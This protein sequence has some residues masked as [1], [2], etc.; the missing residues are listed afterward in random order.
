[1]NAESKDEFNHGT[2]IKMGPNWDRHSGEWVFHYDYPVS[3][4]K[5]TAEELVP[6]IRN[7]LKTPELEIEVLEV[8]HW[9]LE[10]RLA[11]KYRE[12]RLFIAR[13]AAH[14]RPPLTGLGLNTAIED[15]Q[16]L[17][18]KLALVLHNRAKPSLL[19]TYDAERRTVGRRNCDWAYLAYNNTFVLNAAMGLIPGDV[20]HNRERLS[21]L[22]EDSPR[23][24]TARFQLQRIFHTQDIEFM[25]HNIELG[26]VYSSGGAVVPDGTDAP[27]EDPSG[28][29]YVPMTRPGHRLP[30]A[31]IERDGKITST[32]DL[33]GSGNQHDLLLITDETGQPWI[34]A[35][36]IITK[37]SALRI[38]TAAIAAH[39][40]SVGSCLLYQDCDSQWKK[41]RGIN[42]GGAI[43]VRPDNFVLWRS[44]DPSKGDYEELRRDLQ[45]V[46]NI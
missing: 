15:A 42:D 14:R 34:E 29:T 28:R 8:T 4:R 19:D 32:H 3:D 45:M 27:V 10:R 7:L 13:D 21:H 38:G 18:W 36:N 31:W 17:A 22:F 43:L 20:A 2:M 11:T 35:A 39:P 40:Q 1:M 44:V 12:G 6:R 26:F 46:F 41:V 16:N 23:G 37:K 30:H 25:A 33:I 5:F 9:I 24:E